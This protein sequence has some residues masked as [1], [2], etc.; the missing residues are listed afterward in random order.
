M[1][2]QF[3]KQTMHACVPDWYIIV[4]KQPEYQLVTTCIYASYIRWLYVTTWM[5]NRIES[6][7]L[8]CNV[9]MIPFR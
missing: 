4:E 5:L 1:L 3:F 7:L 6:M 9:I 8:S 2:T